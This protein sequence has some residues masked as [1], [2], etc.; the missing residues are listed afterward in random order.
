[1]PPQLCQS[2][3]R[4]IPEGLAECPHCSNTRLEESNNQVKGWS[5]GAF[6]LNWIW[7]IGNKTWIGLLA[8]IPGVGFMVAIVLGIKGREWAWRNRQWQS[9]E[10][11]NQVQKKW[12]FWAVV[13]YLALVWLAVLIYVIT[14]ISN[15]IQNHPDLE[16]IFA[17]APS[18]EEGKPGN[19]S[20]FSKEIFEFA[21]AEGIKRR[22]PAN[23]QADAIC[24]CVVD[25]AEKVIPEDEISDSQ[26]KIIMTGLVKE[27]VLE[28][29]QKGENN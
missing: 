10:Q 22:N 29:K 14:L 24:S 9:L 6:L 16:K 21:C 13:T 15:V 23:L 3:N 18:Q 26:N 27:C 11:F 12:S 8:L 17:H 1:M 19:W 25:K 4:E 20:I 5:W 28:I 7:A 2:C